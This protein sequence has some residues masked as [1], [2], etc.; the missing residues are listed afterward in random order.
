MERTL[1]NN[2]CCFLSFSDYLITK[3]KHFFT[4]RS[5]KNICQA[6]G[7]DNLTV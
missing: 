5:I 2:E 3:S 7:L 6:T 4:I 1:L